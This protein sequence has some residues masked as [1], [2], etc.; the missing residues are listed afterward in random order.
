MSIYLSI[1]LSIHTYI[2]TSTNCM[3]R[4]RLFPPNPPEMGFVLI[5]LPLGRKIF[6]SA[7]SLQ[8]L[9]VIF[10]LT[11][12]APRP[13]LKRCLQRASGCRFLTQNLEALWASNLDANWQVRPELCKCKGCN[14]RLLPDKS[15]ALQTAERPL[16]SG[17]HPLLLPTGGPCCLNTLAP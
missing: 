17:H 11:Q 9:G 1:Y 12:A 5:L 13:R 6:H 3:D 14:Y 10:F 2:H 15:S 7:V 8:C 4:S 16:L